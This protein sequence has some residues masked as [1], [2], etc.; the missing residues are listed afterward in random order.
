MIYYANNVESIRAKGG[1]KR[2]DLIMKFLLQRRHLAPSHTSNLYIPD[3]KEDP[4][5]IKDIPDFFITGHIHR[6]SVSQYKN[7]TLLN[8]SCWSDESEE[9]E[10]R[11]LEAQPGKLPIVNLK[12]REVKIINFMKEKEDKNKEKKGEEESAAGSAKAT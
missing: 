12:T 7:I 6:L 1:Q 9:Q 8:C 3:T 5:I 4:L 2:P 11:G 10:K